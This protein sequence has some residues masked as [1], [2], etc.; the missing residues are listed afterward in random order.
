M[1]AAA[2]CRSLVGAQC[3]DMLRRLRTRVLA[4]A[5][6]SEVMPQINDWIVSA[7]TSLWST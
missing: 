1:A 3:A 4:M 6:K 2:A 5:S 7:F